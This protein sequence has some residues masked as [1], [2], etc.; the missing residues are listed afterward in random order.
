MRAPQSVRSR[1]GRAG[2]SR[3]ARHLRRRGLRVIERNWRC[4]GGEIDL[5]CRD[6][7]Q[8]VV[9]E[10]RTADARAG[11]PFA[12]AP[13]LTVG[14][15][16]RRRLG[17]LAERY[18]ARSTWRPPGGIRIDVVAVVRRGLLHWDVRWFPNA[19]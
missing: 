15:E 17:L 2:E 12:G 10:V 3:A 8:L 7:D 18:L 14:P 1:L 11:R 16:K 13:E 5:V 19:L 9:V 6:G 4:P